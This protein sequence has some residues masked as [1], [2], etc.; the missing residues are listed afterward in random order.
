[1]GLNKR[2]VL[3]RKERNI[4]AILLAWIIFLTL[5]FSGGFKTMTDLEYIEWFMLFIF[6]ALTSIYGELRDMSIKE[7]I[8]DKKLTK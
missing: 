8:K 5:I 6:L 7:W 1:M 3:F 4:L 2:T